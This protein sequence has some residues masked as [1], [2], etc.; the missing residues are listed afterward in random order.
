MADELKGLW[1]SWIDLPAIVEGQWYVLEEN[2]L[3]GMARL[4]PRRKDGSWLICGFRYNQ[5]G[6]P[7]LGSPRLIR[8]C[9]IAPADPAE[10]VADLREMATASHG[11]M[12]DGIPEAYNEAA[13]LVA[14]RLG[15]GTE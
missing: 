8:R 4:D 5:N 10:L 7:C 14:D 2:G 12:P 11:E 15:V 3:A 13:Q 1:D 9:W 6:S